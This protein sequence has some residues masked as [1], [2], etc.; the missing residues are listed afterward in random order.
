MEEKRAADE[1]MRRA[2]SERG[3]PA[4]SAGINT[5]TVEARR[6]SFV[7]QEQAT[8]EDMAALAEMPRGGYDYDRQTI[9]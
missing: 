8:A 5:Q 2:K 4:A 6:A 9:D 7:R 1:A 3:L